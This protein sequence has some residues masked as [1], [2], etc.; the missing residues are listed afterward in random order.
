MRTTTHNS[1]RT[2]SV[3]NSLEGLA[4]LGQEWQKKTL[5]TTEQ[6]KR[7]VPNVHHSIDGSPL[8]T[9][10]Q[11]NLS[12]PKKATLIRMAIAHQTYPSKARLDSESSHVLTS[13]EHFDGDG[14]EFTP[15]DNSPY[16]PVT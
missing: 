2:H 14:G 10:F 7:V 1:G 5:V 6:M 16:V 15:Q 9:A 12:S 13:A 11:A 4:G 8:V 3:G